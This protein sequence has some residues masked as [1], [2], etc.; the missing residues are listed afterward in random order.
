MVILSDGSDLA[1]GCAAYIRWE[2]STGGF[3]CRLIMAK[4][5]IAPQ[6][7]LSTPQMEL[8]G[9]VLSKRTRVVIEKEMRY[10][11]QEVYQLVDSETV[12]AMINKVSTRFKVYEG[13][14]L[15]EIQAA[16]KGDVSC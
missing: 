6:R 4:S 3:W 1:Y 10:K 11:F 8:N 7:K 9:A 12:L 5:R 13:V 2:L 14:R 16:T 15:G